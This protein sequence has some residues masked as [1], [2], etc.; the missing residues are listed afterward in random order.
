MTNDN[1]CILKTSIEIKNGK[2]Q[3]Y[4]AV[5]GDYIDFVYDNIKGRLVIE[6]NLKDKRKLIVSYKNKQKEILYSKI[7]RLQISDLLYDKNEFKYDIGHIYQS[8]LSISKVIDRFINHGRKYKIKCLTCGY[9]FERTESDVERER[10]CPCC[11][12][13]I[14]VSGIND[15]W[16]TNPELA[17]L[18]SD[19]NDGYKY[20]EFANQILE[21]KCPD[22][23]EL[24]H[25][26]VSTVNERGL[27]CRSCGNGISYPN[28]F[29][30]NF[31]KN[32]N[33]NFKSEKTFCWSN[34]RIYDFYLEDYNYII[35]VHGMQHYKDCGFKVNVIEQQK[36]DDYKKRL[37]NDN[38]IDKYIVIDCRY[39]DKNFIINNIKNS[40]LG[41]MFDL[42][43]IDIDEIDKK[44]REKI[45]FEIAKMY[46]NNISINEISEIYKLTSTSVYNYLH[47]ADNM[48]IINFDYNKSN[49]MR[50]KNGQSTYYQNHST[51][52]KCVENG[53]YFGSLVLI[54][55]NSEKI[56]GKKMLK[57]CI[58][59][60]LKNGKQTYGYTFKYVP[61]K[62]FNHQKRIN[63]YKVFGDEF[64][65]ENINEKN[66]KNEQKTS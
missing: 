7:I 47:K 18:L 35:E 12:G 6:D 40:I 17:K 38:K 48:G 43:K 29:M 61:R 37:A 28:R 56:F 11:S 9:E 63:P 64:Y 49:R 14:V 52:I 66:I 16:T 53:Y 46:K 22:C 10:G 23:G 27:G 5:N 45:I 44:S 54:E 59:T 34:G 50:S 32:L 21:W 55:L 57:S 3:W 65:D 36:I 51:P 42:S 20:T 41:K 26:I 13:R 1:R 19:P 4:K 39:S 31:L 30:F 62:E 33:I 60:A 25:K 2:Y 58:Y 15:M 24:I 8:T